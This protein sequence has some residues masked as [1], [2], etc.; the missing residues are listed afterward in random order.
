MKILL[1]GSNGMLGQSINKVF[2]DKGINVITAAKRD[3]DY[4]FDFTD[5]TLLEHCI[6]DANPDIIINTS[7][8]VDLSFCENEPEK[9]YL[10]NA[11]ILGILANICKRKNIYL[12]HISTDHYYTQGK[13]IKHNENENV[14]LVNEY[15]RT[16]YLGEQLALTH[17]NTL[18][19][20]TN[21]I[22]FRGSE[23]PTFIEWVIGE[24]EKGSQFNLFTDFYTS[25]IH[26]TEFAKI[27]VDVIAKHP[28]GIYNLASSEVS[29]KK[30]F[31]LSISHALF[32]KEPDY[33]EASVLSINDP[34]RA[35]SLGLDTSKIES[36]IGYTMPNLKET[37]DSIVI[38]YLDRKNT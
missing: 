28:T 24:L 2:S 34:K 20:R 21:I 19:L 11:R 12:I 26:T 15:A 4:C 13:H 22:G 35:S 1:L 31:I 9:A 10:V 8:I 18:V 16:K 3:A 17:Q 6:D 33:K 25:S 14:E 7:A 23:K 5:D 38:D 32:K 36:L 27:L 30:D 37:V 29:S